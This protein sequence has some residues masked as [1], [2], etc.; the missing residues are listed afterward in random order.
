MMVVVEVIILIMLM[1]V[2]T[3]MMLDQV[4]DGRKFLTLDNVYRA[5]GFV[6]ALYTIMSNVDL[7]C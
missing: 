1:L 2:H 3:L 6:W 5:A 4:I 7:I